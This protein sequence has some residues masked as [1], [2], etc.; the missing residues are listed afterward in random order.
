[1]PPI[2]FNS[3][4]THIFVSVLFINPFIETLRESSSTSAILGANTASNGPCLRNSS[5]LYILIHFVKRIPKAFRF[6]SLAIICSGIFINKPLFVEFVVAVSIKFVGLAYI[7]SWAL[8]PKYAV[9]LIEASI[10][11]YFNPRF[12]FNGG[13]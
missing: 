3:N 11:I 4:I 9:G 10:K 8:S 2:S 13:P 6:A 12:I 1:M 7:Y 5:R